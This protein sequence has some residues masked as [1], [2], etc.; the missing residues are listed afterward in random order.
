MTSLLSV[1][2]LPGVG[3]HLAQVPPGYD[4]PLDG[5]GVTDHGEPQHHDLEPGDLHPGDVQ[6]VHVETEDGDTLVT[7]AESKDKIVIIYTMLENPA[8]MSE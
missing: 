8:E 5:G 1:L 2:P 4:G 3:V 6:I 7:G